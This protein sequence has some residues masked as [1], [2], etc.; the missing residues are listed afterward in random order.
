MDADDIIRI[1]FSCL[2]GV[3][4]ETLRINTDSND[5]QVAGPRR[6]FNDLE[7]VRRLRFHATAAK[8]VPH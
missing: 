8:Q 3:A 6:A 5:T 2:A 1:H 4:C 7:I